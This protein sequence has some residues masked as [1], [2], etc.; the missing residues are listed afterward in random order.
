[1]SL[2]RYGKTSGDLLIVVSG[3]G[4]GIQKDE[5][6][7][8]DWAGAISQ[9]LDAHYPGHP[10]I[11]AF[12]GKALI[13]RHVEIAH[14]VM[15]ATGKSGFGSVLPPHRYGTRKEAIA[16]AVKGAGEMLEA[17]G[18]PRGKWN[19]GTP[20]KVPDWNRGKTAGFT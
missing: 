19:E 1:L 11:V 7:D 12:Q 17:F 13:L 3:E 10:W 14:A 6:T 9:A 2:E 20:P 18:M 8:E 15:M 5:G 4:A 16:S